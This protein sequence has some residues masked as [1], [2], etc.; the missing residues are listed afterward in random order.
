MK[1]VSIRRNRCSKQFVKADHF[2]QAFDF[3][4]PDNSTKLRTVPGAICW[5]LMMVLMCGYAGYRL[6]LM[7]TFQLY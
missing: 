3:V 1:V 7:F 2:G 5:L 4:L 6:A